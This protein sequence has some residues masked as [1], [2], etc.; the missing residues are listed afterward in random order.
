MFFIV[1]GI[2]ADIKDE[3]GKE[4]APPQEK[5]QKPQK[6]LVCHDKPSEKLTDLE[7]TPER[8]ESGDKEEK[9]EAPAVWKE[10]EFE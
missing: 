9:A 10:K 1:L 8:E 3:R 2:A 4:R 6:D 5:I 7:E